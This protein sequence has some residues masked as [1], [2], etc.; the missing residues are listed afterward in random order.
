M[1]LCFSSTIDN[2]TSRRANGEQNY[3]IGWIQ[4]EGE[5]PSISSDIAT[6]SRN[7]TDNGTILA[8]PGQG[9]VAGSSIP[10]QDWLAGIDA[11]SATLGVLVA[12]GHL[13]GLVFYMVTLVTAKRLFF[14][15]H[16]RSERPL[17]WPAAKVSGV[18]LAWLVG[19]GGIGFNLAA[20][21]NF[22]ETIISILHD[23]GFLCEVRRSACATL[24]ARVG[25]NCR[26]LDTT[27]A[28]IVDIR[29]GVL[30][31]VYSCVRLHAFCNVNIILEGIDTQHLLSTWWIRL[32]L[33]CRTW[34][35]HGAYHTRNEL[36]VM[37]YS[38]VTRMAAHGDVEVYRVPSQYLCC[39]LWSL[40]FHAR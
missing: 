24:L 16:F 12:V 20:Q 25:C 10:E 18:L 5:G 8:D 13:L 4:Y 34:T 11:T 1:N 40:V 26:Q 39:R 31:F 33:F 32:A 6:I 38:R 3:R 36:G 17:F 7:S 22:K 27:C 35:H 14:R 23:D 28:L 9:G 15:T 30:F 19:F 37:L 29:D 2:D 21:E